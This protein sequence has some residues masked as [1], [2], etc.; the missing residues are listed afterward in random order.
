MSDGE[1]ELGG[2][3][4]YVKNGGTRLASGNLTESTTFLFD[5]VKKAIEFGI[6]EN[7]AFKM[8][9]ENPYNM[10]GIKNRGKIEEGYTADFILQSS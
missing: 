10:M 5:M 2:L 1:Y 7:E 8:A 6:P 9:S 3:T 4:T